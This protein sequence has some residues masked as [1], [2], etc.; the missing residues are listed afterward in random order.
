VYVVVTSYRDANADVVGSYLRISTVLVSYQLK[1]PTVSSYC[2]VVLILLVT[3]YYLRQGYSSI[4]LPISVQWYLC[5]YLVSFLKQRERDSGRKIANSMYQIR[6][7]DYG[8]SWVCLS[9][10][11]G[12]FSW[13]CFIAR[14]NASA[15]CD[16]LLCLS[17][18]L[19]QVEL[20]PKWLKTGSCKR[21]RKLAPEIWFSDAKDLGDSDGSN[22]IGG[23]KYKWGGLKSAVFDQYLF[24]SKT[25]QNGNAVRVLDRS[26]R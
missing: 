16:V 1:L 4:D 9:E 22:F 7:G 5:S 26:D 8:F 3:L 11:N 2:R 6:Q 12:K 18:Y 10:V 14:R 24:I 13:I 19:S 15:V 23:V 21:R 17:V 20:L 25:V